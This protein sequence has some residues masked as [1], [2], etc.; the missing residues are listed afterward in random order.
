[1]PLLIYGEM[2]MGNANVV[3]S[4]T[5]L[6]KAVCWI[7]EIMQEHP[8]KERKQVLKDAQMRFDLN[9]V[10]CEFLTKNFAEVAAGKSC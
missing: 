2:D 5:N 8:E 6:Q 1:V 4:S 7:G 9:P 3:T 10:E